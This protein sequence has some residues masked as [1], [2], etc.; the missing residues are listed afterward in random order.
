MIGLLE[1]V[2]GRQESHHVVFAQANGAVNAMGGLVAGLRAELDNE[3]L[4]RRARLRAIVYAPVLAGLNDMGDIA[5]LDV[6][7]SWPKR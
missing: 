5:Q 4:R 7:W 6:E 3:R 1:A 2:W